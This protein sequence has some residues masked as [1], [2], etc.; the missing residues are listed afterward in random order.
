MLAEARIAR[1]PSGGLCLWLEPVG[2]G[3]ITLL[4]TLHLP[5]ASLGGL[6]GGCVGGFGPQLS[7]GR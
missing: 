5:E 7:A 3:R 6:S 2:C 4:E 1:G